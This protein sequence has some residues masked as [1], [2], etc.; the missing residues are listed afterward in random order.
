MN[1]RIRNALMVGVALTS[2]PALSS[3]SSDTNGASA[4]KTSVIST[5]S[6]LAVADNV[7]SALATA[8]ESQLSKTH[9]LESKPF[10]PSGANAVLTVFRSEME[11]DETQARTLENAVHSSNVSGAAT[12]ESHI[13][14]AVVQFTDAASALASAS[15]TSAPSAALHESV[16]AS[17]SL[18]SPFETLQRLGATK[19]GSISN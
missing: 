13:Q 18:A 15:T 2:V 12:M 3:C 4:T 6:L 19:C 11:T 1:K 17:L 16:K 8:Q 7:C 5:A 14:Q 9:V 10:T